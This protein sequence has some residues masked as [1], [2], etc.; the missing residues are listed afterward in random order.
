ME[1]VIL[2]L[3][4][5]R[6][7][8]M[9][10]LNKA[11]EETISL[12]YSASFGSISSA[13]ARLSEKGWIVAREQVEQGRNKKLYAPTPAGEAAFEEWL[14]SQ[15]PGEKVKDPALTRLFFL[16]FLPPQGRVAVIEAHLASLEAQHASLEL[17]ER[18]AEAAEIPEARR[19]QA[20]FQR[21]TLRYGREYYAFSI[22][23]YKQL[24]DTLK[25]RSDDRCD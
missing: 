22:G 23:W 1:Y 7:Q 11:L 3:L 14:G 5:L 20:T 13:L 6:E 15:I 8:S 16:G 9:Y 24:L 2:G 19:E 18:Q 21:L 10:E 17:L 12:F 4:M 25:E